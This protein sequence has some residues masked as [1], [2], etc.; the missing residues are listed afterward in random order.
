MIVWWLDG[1]HCLVP[2]YKYTTTDL[3]DTLADTIT[4]AQIR[5]GGRSMRKIVG[6][7]IAGRWNELFRMMMQDG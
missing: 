1:M 3:Q 4:G 7:A 5:E 2:V 6:R